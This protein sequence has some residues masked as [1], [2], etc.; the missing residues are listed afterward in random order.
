[1]LSINFS[2]AFIIVKPLIIFVLAMSIYSVFVFKFYRFL[3]KKD[4]IE[5]N[6]KIYNRANHWI[7]KTVLGIVFYVIEYIM[8]LPIVIFI[9]FAVLAILLTFLARNQPIESILL[10]AIAVVGA[11]R[12]T[13]YYNEDLAKDLAKMLPFALLGVFL[14][15]ISYFNIE[16]SIEMIK[17][18]KLHTDILI[19]Y[20]GFIVMLE[21][22]LRIIY[23]ITFPF[24]AEDEKIKIKLIEE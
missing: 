12:I 6:L 19:Y 2:Q 17:N 22:I 13:S 21:L 4:I 3:A 5:F 1:M 8:F 23:I 9:W 15:D 14:V 16:T 10:V 20:L 24:I 18:V 7:L 11:V